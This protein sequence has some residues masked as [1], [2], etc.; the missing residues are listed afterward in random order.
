MDN[1]QKTL[2]VY[3]TMLRAVHWSPISDPETEDYLVAQC[4]PTVESVRRRICL[5]GQPFNTHTTTLAADANGVDVP[6]EYLAIRFPVD[7][8]DRLTIFNGKVYDRTTQ[9]NW[10]TALAVDVVLNIALTELPPLYLE[11][12]AKEAAEEF[13]VQVNG[14]TAEVSYLHRQALLAK[15]AALNSEPVQALD[16]MVGFTAIRGA[17]NV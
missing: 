7:L 16:A 13:A 9:Q 11:W 10:T 8:Q 17:F 14:M 15:Q 5:S 6:D 4:Q 12:L 2:Y 1:S 3:N